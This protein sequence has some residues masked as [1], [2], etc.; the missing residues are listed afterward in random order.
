MYTRTC[1]AKDVYIK[2]QVVN[3]VVLAITQPVHSLLQQGKAQTPSAFYLV[4]VVVLAFTQLA[5]EGTDT[6][7]L[8]LS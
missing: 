2:W 5:G 4:N 7:C 3:V 1:S 8:L 6:K